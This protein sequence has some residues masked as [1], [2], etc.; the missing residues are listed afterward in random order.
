MTSNVKVYRHRPQ[1]GVRIPP[2]AP[3]VCRPKFLDPWDKNP[4]I[5]KAREQRLLRN[6][7]VDGCILAEDRVDEEESE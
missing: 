1:L 6:L 5:I 3:Q 7:R 2:R 4:L